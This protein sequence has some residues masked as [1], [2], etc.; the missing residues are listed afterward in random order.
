MSGNLI[1]LLSKNYKDAFLTFDPNITFF[2]TL[3]LRHTPFS[4]DTI[5]EPFNKTP[6]FSEECFCELSKL[7]DL[8]T[9]MFLKIVL[10]SVQISNS[11]D[12]ANL[13][14]YSTT[15]IT[16]ESYVLTAS[17][18]ITQYNAK[19]TSFKLFCSSA[20]VYWRSIKNILDDSTSNYNDVISLI[21]TSLST[22]NDVQNIYDQYNEFQTTKVNDSAL[23]FNFNILI[24]IKNE[25]RAYANSIYNEALTLEYKEKVRLYLSDFAFNQRKY[26]QF[27]IL[28]RD[29]FVAI[30]AKHDT[31]YYKFAWVNNIA[32]ALI[33][34]INIEIGG[35]NVD[36]FTSHILN[37]WY[38]MATKIEF[39]DTLNKLIGNTQVLTTY[40]T[41]QKPTYTLYIPIPTWFSRYKQEPLQCVSMRHQDIIVKVKLNELYKC[42]YFEP[43]EF[44]SYTSNININDDIKIQGISLIVDYIHLGDDERNKFSTLSLESLIEQHRILSYSSTT[45]DVQLS[46]DFA[47]SIKDLFWTVQKEYNV[48]KMKLWNDY[49]TFDSYPALISV[50]GQVD[51]YV[52]Y[53][54]IQL[55]NGTIF[56]NYLT[57]HED[58]LYGYCEIYHSKYYDGSYKILG[59]N[60]QYL[61]I[62]NKNFIYPDSIKIKLTQKDT[63]QQQI[64]EKENILI[65]GKDLI[66]SR[67]PMFFTHVQDRGRS[68]TSTDIHK[69]SLSLNPEN[70]QPSGSLNFNVIKNK[71]LQM[72]IN[73]KVIT[74]IIQNNDKI[75]TR[76]VSKNYNTLYI[77][78]GYSNLVFGI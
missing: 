58:Y 52:G 69:Y 66:I 75:I 47:N 56:D 4:I 71:S 72:V 36:H 64:I 1:Q 27:L 8:I 15:E 39:V 73:D 33:N 60:E 70:H 13:S 76:I 14:D 9:N 32:F 74:Q 59:T 63:T 44:G 28:S 31:T 7:G 37:N 11:L 25:F 5:E 77:T 48:E 68:K 26:L 49:T 51:P 38:S 29:K 19:I 22:Q 67:D 65:Y 78:K 42:C 46:L 17:D 21:S 54:Y 40:D 18:M 12:S 61:I 53:I 6:N 62:E 23:Y 34:Y 50:V 24:Y 45:K 57:N 2:K 55:S 43:D 41:E 20:M 16:Y 3:Y 35:Q 10:P 30:K